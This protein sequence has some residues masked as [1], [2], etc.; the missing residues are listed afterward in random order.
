MGNYVTLMGHAFDQ[1]LAIKVRELQ[2]QQPLGGK[3]HLQGLVWEIATRVRGE[4]EQKMKT[5]TKD[6]MMGLVGMMAGSGDFRSILKGELQKDR[7]FSWEVSNMGTL[8][9]GVPLTAN[10]AE[11]AGEW[12][13]ERLVSS[14][15]AVANGAAILVFPISLKGGALCTTITAQKGVV[16]E[17]LTEGLTADLEDWFSHLSGQ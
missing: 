4:L 16:D 2:Q 17:M 3:E 11:N 14:Q 9:A 8:D 13:L 6:D 7:E 1:N 12:R 5:G 15:S 10:G